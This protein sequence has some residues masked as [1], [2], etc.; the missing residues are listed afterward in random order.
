MLAGSSVRAVSIVSS[1]FPAFN[2]A[3]MR[4]DGVVSMQES[5][6]AGPVQL[7]QA[8]VVGEVCLQGATIGQDASAV[9]VSAN[10]LSVDGDVNC[11]RLVTRGA[12]SMDALQVTGSLD[13]TGARVSRRAHGHS[14][15]G[16]PR[17]LEPQ[18]PAR[19]RLRWLARDEHGQRPQPYEQLAD[20]YNA[21]GQPAEA[22]HVLYARERLQRRNRAPLARTWRFLQDVTV[23]YGYQPRR[24]LLWMVLLLAVG[25]VVFTLN[26]PPPLPG[27]VAPHF[28]AVI[29][30][31]DLLLPVVDLGQKHAFNPGGA[32]QWFAYLLTGAGWVLATTIAAGAARVLSRRLPRQR[33]FSHK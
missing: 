14:R 7:D 12:V 25:S 11:A 18:L 6:G 8:R 29:Y 31:L 13:L 20:H 1:R 5:S 27:G 19:Q 15:S 24:A 23:G 30:T 4:V 32:E 26:P 17:S 28:N 33:A 16:T 10:G 22:R 3:R 2:G 21:L 9:A